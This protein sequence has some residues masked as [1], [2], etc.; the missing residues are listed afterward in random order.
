MFLAKR[1]KTVRP[2]GRSKLHPGPTPHN[3]ATP[4]GKPLPGPRVLYGYQWRDATRSG[5]DPIPA[6]A[7]IVQ[8]I[9]QEAAAGETLRQIAMRL[10][11]DSIPTPVRGK[12]TAWCQDT[13]RWIVHHPSYAGRATGWR[14]GRD[15]ATGTALPDGAIPAPRLSPCTDTPSS[16]P[17]LRRD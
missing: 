5:Y 15:C 4:S 9:Y 1:R 12:R 11:A 10:T 14:D 17:K 2:S 13:I 7:R 16:S 3:T 8:R 6:T